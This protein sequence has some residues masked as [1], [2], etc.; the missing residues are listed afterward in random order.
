MKSAS[1]STDSEDHR[2][3]RE[4]A[5][6]APEVVGTSQ[7]VRAMTHNQVQV[8]PPNPQKQNLYL[9]VWTL[10]TNNHKGRVQPASKDT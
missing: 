9:A 7:A 5:I 8:Q 6:R 3:M 2:M 4:G 1:N 10:T